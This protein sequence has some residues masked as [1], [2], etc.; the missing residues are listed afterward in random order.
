MGRMPTCCKITLDLVAGVRVDLELRSPGQ[1]P[2]VYFVL[3]RDAGAQW[4]GH[5]SRRYFI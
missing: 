2:S 4:I 3:M 5:S 1:V